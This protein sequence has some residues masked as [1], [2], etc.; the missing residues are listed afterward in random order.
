MVREVIGPVT[1]GRGPV[2]L[3]TAGEE[4]EVA[5]GIDP[6]GLDLL[7]AQGAGEIEEAGTGLQVQ[8]QGDLAVEGQTDLLAEDLTGQMPGDQTDLELA[9]DQETLET[10]EV[11]QD[12]REMILLGQETEREIT[13]PQD[14]VATSTL[15]EV[16]HIQD[17]LVRMVEIKIRK[18]DLPRLN[19]RLQPQPHKQLQLVR[20]ATLQMSLKQDELRNHNMV[21]NQKFTQRDTHRF[22]SLGIRLEHIR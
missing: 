16:A 11:T 15:I 20:P 21:L 18:S 5:E 7:T 8:G 1:A 2:L 9:E 14:Q 10:A 6:T 12:L 19:L 3:K 13:V 4:K 22:I 17:H